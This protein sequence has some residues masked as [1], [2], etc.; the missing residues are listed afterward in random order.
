MIPNP[1]LCP[2][3]I[4]PSSLLFGLPTPLVTPI[5]RVS[6]TLDLDLRLSFPV[7]SLHLLLFLL[8]MYL[9]LLHCTLNG[10]ERSGLAPG[11]RVF[12]FV[13]FCPGPSFFFFFFFSFI[14]SDEFTC[15]VNRTEHIAS[16]D[17]N[18]EFLIFMWFRMTIYQSL[19]KL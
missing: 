3:S 6:G 2:I 10:V 18:V 5:Y 4:V 11:H 7:Y 1:L 9:L 12:S 19:M 15:T 17:R 14:F 8:L 13:S 16:S